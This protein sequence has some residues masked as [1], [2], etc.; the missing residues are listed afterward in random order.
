MQFVKFRL[1]N[2]RFMWQ[3]S[4]ILVHKLLSSGHCGYEKRLYIWTP[5]YPC[6]DVLLASMLSRGNSKNFQSLLLR[7]LAIN[8]TGKNCGPEL[9]DSCTERTKPPLKCVKQKL[10][11]HGLKPPDLR[12]QLH[13]LWVDNCSWPTEYLLC[14]VG[15]VGW[16]W[17]AA[18]IG[19][20]LIR[21]TYL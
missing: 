13:Y 9:T 17:K 14:S 21:K 20:N 12:I 1:W 16:I 11:D 5:V 7:S 2:C 18:Q 8:W 19:L 3:L 6:R 15:S 4:H 10:H